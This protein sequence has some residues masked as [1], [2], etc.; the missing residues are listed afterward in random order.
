MA[1]GPAFQVIVLVFSPS[2]IAISHTAFSALDKDGFST[3]SILKAAL[4]LAFASRRSEADSRT[5]KNRVRQ[6]VLAKTW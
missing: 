3:T 1:G 2:L 6:V 5:E 4:I